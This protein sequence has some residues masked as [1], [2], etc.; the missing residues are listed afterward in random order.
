MVIQTSHTGV[1]NPVRKFSQ[2]IN[3]MVSFYSFYA[4]GKQGIIITKQEENSMRNSLKRKLRL[5]VGGVLM[6]LG[7][8]LLFEKSSVCAAENVGTIQFYHAHIGDSEN[9]GG[10]YG[11]YVTTSR[12]CGSHNLSIWDNTQGSYNYLCNQCGNQWVY[13]YQLSGVYCHNTISESHYE[14]NCGMDNT[15]L[16]TLSCSKSEN[17]WTKAVDLTA[18]CQVNHSS[19]CLSATPYVWNGNASASATYH[20]TQNGTYTLG[21]QAQGNTDLS[22]KISVTVNNIDNQAPTIH[23]FSKSTE[24]WSQKVELCVRAEDMASGLAAQAYSYDGGASWTDQSSFIAEQNGTYSVIVRDAVGNQSTAKTE[25]MTIDRTAPT[26]EIV[27]SPA[28]GDWY[29]GDLTVTILASDSES[30]LSELPYSFDGGSSFLVGNSYKISSDCELQIV[31]SDKA[32]N[33]KMLTLSAVKKT[34]PPKPADSTTAGNQSGSGTTSTGK[35]SGSGNEGLGGQ[36]GSSEQVGE[37]QGSRTTMGQEMS[38]AKNGTPESETSETQNQGSVNSREQ[39]SGVKDNSFEGENASGKNGTS[40]GKNISIEESLSEDKE[41]SEGILEQHYPEVFWQG[42]PVRT[43]GLKKGTEESSNED[44]NL[45]EEVE[46]EETVVLNEFLADEANR[47]MYTLKSVGKNS[48]SVMIFVTGTV[49]VLCI[50][51]FAAGKKMMIV[52]AKNAKGSFCI[53]GLTKP[54]CKDGRKIVYISDAMLRRA[55]TNEFRIQLPILTKLPKEGGQI[56]VSCHGSAREIPM[57]RI[58]S[59]RLRGE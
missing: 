48:R 19:F 39:R 34:R 59:I 1:Q 49:F 37:T 5:F 32:G 21:I 45:S 15:V 7:N 52:S 18:S 24:S 3:R 28:L 12:E 41:Q 6:L 2:L 44:E 4:C 9:G 29:D 47:D 38:G 54:C 23:T 33:R 22:Q 13:Q 53:V 27:T 40:S 14:R 35:Q 11:K 20:V 25:I 17:G 57:Q 26:A 36:S 58:L 46:S 31:V 43:K 30:G 56:T 16:A 51:I 42:T 10:C 8:L 55:Q 50:A